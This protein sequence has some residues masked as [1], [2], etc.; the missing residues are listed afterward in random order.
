MQQPSIAAMFVPIMLFTLIA[1]VVMAYPIYRIATN[2]GSENSWWAFVPIANAV[3]LLNLGDMSGWWLL[4]CLVP[5]VGPIVL[6]V[7]SVIA[8]MN[9]CEKLGQERLLGLLQIVPIINIVLLYYL[10]FTA[11]PRSDVI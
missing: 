8:M 10:A 3:L 1:Y 2:L 5:F 6:M 4:V 9:L 11:S 7:V